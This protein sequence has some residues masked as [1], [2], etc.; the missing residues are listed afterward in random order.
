MEFMNKV[1]VNWVGLIEEAKEHIDAMKPWDILGLYMTKTRGVMD[2]NDEA[3]ASVVEAGAFRLEMKRG[4]LYWEFAMP[5]TNT[6]VIS[7]RQEITFLWDEFVPEADVISYRKEIAI[8]YRDVGIAGFISVVKAEM[9]ETMARKLA[10]DLLETD[11][12]V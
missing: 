11:K 8:P 6:A 12:E 5:K 10:H 3:F 7:C 2:A 9:N 4:E 1:N